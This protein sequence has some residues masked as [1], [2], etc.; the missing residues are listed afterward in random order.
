M[1]DAQ[2]PEGSAR[3]RGRVP[4]P[5]LVL[6]AGVMWSLGGLFVKIL[7]VHFEVD[8][9]AIGCLRSAAGGLVLAW[10]L[11]RLG[12]PPKL[13]VGAAALA[14]TVV[15]GGFCVAMSGTTAANA[16]FLQYTYP[17]FVA[18]GAVVLLGERLRG[19]TVAAL[20]L[21]LGGVAVIFVGSW[22]PVQQ[23]GIVYGLVS[24][25]ALGGFTLLQRSMTRGNPVALS[26]LYNLVAAALMLPLAWG[27]LR[28]P[29]PAL[30]VAA[31]MGIMQL[32]V[33]YV[34]FI[35]GLRTVPATDA[36]LITLVEPLLTP[37]W[38]WLAVREAP[39][40]PTW[41]GGV[42]ILAALLLRFLG[43]RRI[44]AAPAT[45]RD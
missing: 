28:V 6:A 38:V 8:P 25:A 44:E 36:A 23:E 10:A 14:Y 33:P 42:L 32:S 15:V 43:A 35:K 7:K 20:G 13:K 22:E 39:L 12:R 16:I 30:L 17:L 26:S 40:A 45:E 29:W 2:P 4:G 31:A 9:W 24:G 11:P 41:A 18:V 37:L 21:G 19:R 5:L 34:L 3:P 1:T 27:A